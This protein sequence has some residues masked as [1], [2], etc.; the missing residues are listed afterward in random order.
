MKVGR[1]VGVVALSGA[2]LGVAGVVVQTLPAAAVTYSAGESCPQSLAGQTTVDG[3]GRTLVCENQNGWHWEL[4][5]GSAAATTTAPV[6]TTTVPPVVTTS[7]PVTTLATPATTVTTAATALPATNASS[8][9]A[10]PTTGAGQPLAVLA[11]TGFGSMVVAVGTLGF[12]RLR[13]RL[14][15]H[16]RRRHS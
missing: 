14:G 5:S 3:N 2:G 10:L 8:G 11:V 1:L 12:L 7:V 16:F 4:A 15:L 9:G 13:L 6:A